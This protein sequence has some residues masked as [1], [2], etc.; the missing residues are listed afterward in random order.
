MKGNKLNKQNNI[1]HY[2]ICSG[3]TIAYIKS[4]HATSS[5]THCSFTSSLSHTHLSLSLY[6]GSSVQ[7]QADDLYIPSR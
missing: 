3:T 1:K 6:I 7:K 5:H 2:S 4:L